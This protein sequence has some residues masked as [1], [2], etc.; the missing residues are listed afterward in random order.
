MKD[1][2]IVIKQ[3]GGSKPLRQS[4]FTF[5]KISELF[6]FLFTTA[7]VGTGVKCM[8]K[9]QYDFSV[10][11]GATGAYNLL[12]ETELIPA[13][14]V[15]TAVYFDTVTAPTSGGSAT[16]A[17][18]VN[19]TTDLKG[20]TAYGSFSG[21]TAGIPVSSAATS[22]KV[23]AASNLVMTIGTAALTAGKINVFVEYFISE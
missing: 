8:A 18:G 17:L 11:G 21:I 2:H 20:A 1:Q 19:T 22:V 3:S 6:P 16:I 14:A 15:I 13:K 5:K 7:P 23:T 9:G 10:S 12:P 4:K